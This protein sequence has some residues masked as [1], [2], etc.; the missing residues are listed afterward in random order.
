MGYPLIILDVSHVT[1]LRIFQDKY[2]ST[3]LYQL[4]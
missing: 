3:N 4:V 2:V 1:Y